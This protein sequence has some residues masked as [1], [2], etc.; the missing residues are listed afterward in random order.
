MKCLLLI[1]A[2][3]VSAAYGQLEQSPIATQDLLHRL[4]E[5]KYTSESYLTN[6]L[7]TTGNKDTALA[8]Y[9]T[10]RWKMDGL[11]YS[12]SAAMIT[13]NSPHK[14]KLLNAWCL[15]QPTILQNGKCEKRSIQLYAQMLY[16]LNAISVKEMQTNSVQQK[17]LNLTTNVF[18]LLKDSYTIVKGL[19][20]LKTQK[21]MA[22]VEILDHARLLSPGE[23]MKTGVK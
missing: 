5:I 2:F 4:F 12:L 6:A 17:T 9:N 3:F 10:V 23:L 15:A 11:V 14:I 7:K 8:V 20:D 1:G 22:L 16:E 19:S 13:E 21:T 18:Y